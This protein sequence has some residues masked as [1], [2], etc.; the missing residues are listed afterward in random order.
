MH[1]KGSLW[2]SGAAVNRSQPGRRRSRYLSSDM[3]SG[4]FHPFPDLETY[5]AWWSRAILLNRYEAGVG[6]ARLF[7]TQG[8][9]RA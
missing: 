8:I 2:T 3:Y 6:K 5:W 9:R 1:P 7:Y 4:G